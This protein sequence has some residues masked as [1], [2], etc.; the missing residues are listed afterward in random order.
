MKTFKI[1]LTFILTI[2]SAVL[3]QAQ[4]SLMMPSQ[5]E[6]SKERNWETRLSDIVLA[7]GTYNRNLG[8]FSDV[9]NKAAGFNL[10][11]GKEYSNKYHLILK[12]GYSS[13]STRMESDT[14]SLH[15][16][17]IQ[18]GVRYYV[19]RSRLMPYFSFVNGLN[20]ITQDRDIYGNKGDRT[21]ARYMWQA[22]CGLVIKVIKELNIDL[23]AKYNNNFYDPAYMMTS[24][25][26]SAGLSYNLHKIKIF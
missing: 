5:N 10:T 25:E 7:E 23:S 17:P 11:Y 6:T 1:I 12:T 4:N 18:I 13:Y 14:A 16:I 20:I 24:F 26:Y 3:V 8:T 2:M 22:G 15:A 9:Y 21:M 19:L